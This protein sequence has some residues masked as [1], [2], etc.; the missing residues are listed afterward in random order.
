MVDIEINTWSSLFNIKTILNCR[1][2]SK[3]DLSDD[4]RRSWGSCIWFW[5]L[6]AEDRTTTS[7][8]SG[9]D[10]HGVGYHWFESVNRYYI[11]FVT[12]L[13]AKEFILTFQ[14]FIRTSVQRREGRNEGILTNKHE[15][16]L[17]ERVWQRFRSC[18]IE[19]S[20]RMNWV[21]TLEHSEILQ[22]RWGS[23]RKLLLLNKN[24]YPLREQY[25][26]PGEPEEDVGTSWNQLLKL[27]EQFWS[28]CGTFWSY[29][30]P[31]D[32]MRLSWI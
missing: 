29:H 12:H 25:K 19:F 21:E 24:Q 10:N 8:R 16:S 30:W 23:I 4:L 11:N 28:F 1:L 20:S 9:G 17:E 6:R 31:W 2:G 22:E 5:T 18:R 27:W 13:E 3:P 26:V 15:I 14:N 32:D 7:R